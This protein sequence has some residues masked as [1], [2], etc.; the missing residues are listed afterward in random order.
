MIRSLVLVRHGETDANAAGRT[1]ATSDPPLNDRGRVQAARVGQL[2]AAMEF[3]LVTTSPR[4]RCRETAEAIVACQNGR[5]DVVVN[6]QLVE[7]GLGAFEGRSVSELREQ[8]LEEVFL[9]WRQGAP[10]RYP[11]GAE[12]FE[13]AAERMSEVFDAIVASGVETALVIGHS[14]ALRILIASRILGGT[15]DM[16]RR[17]FLDNASVTSVFWEVAIPRLAMLNG[18]VVPTTGVPPIARAVA[19]ASLKLE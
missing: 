10:P 4:R 14:H 17:L 2:L 8:G 18:D 15:P 6:D 13:S 1:I 3:E 16:H 12:S 9:A 11:P 5:T 7:L 19:A